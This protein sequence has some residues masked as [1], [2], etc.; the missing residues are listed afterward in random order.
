MYG[1]NLKVRSTN[2]F[3]TSMCK[4][5]SIFKNHERFYRP[6]FFSI[7]FCNFNPLKWLKLNLAINARE[8]ATLISEQLSKTY[9]AITTIKFTHKTLEAVTLHLLLLNLL[10]YNS[11]LLL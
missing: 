4:N 11:H 7:T 3:P 2:L 6:F 8:M 9:K 10:Y 1:R 5:A